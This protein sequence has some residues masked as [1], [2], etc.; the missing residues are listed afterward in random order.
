MNINDII[1]KIYDNMIGVILVGMEEENYNEVSNEYKRI[2]LNRYSSISI[3]GR[4]PE[5]LYD[6]ILKIEYD[7]WQ[8]MA[9]PMKS[10][11]LIKDKS[12]DQIID[13][14]NGAY[15][16][17]K[18]RLYDGKTISTEVADSNKTKME[19]LYNDVKEYNK[20]LADWHISEGTMDLEYASGRTENTSLRI[21][22]MR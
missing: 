19:E 21:G 18:E 9:P 14:A 12:L 1:N 6:K 20:A 17:A 5:E 13:I 4:D 8:P 2:L 3:N 22:R 16:A 11:I 15:K 10:H 7:E